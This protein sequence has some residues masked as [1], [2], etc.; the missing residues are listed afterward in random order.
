MADFDN[1]VEQIILDKSFELPINVVNEAKRNAK[2]KKIATKR[3]F[4]LPKFD[5]K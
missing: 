5:Q 1:N 2:Q 4:T 3:T